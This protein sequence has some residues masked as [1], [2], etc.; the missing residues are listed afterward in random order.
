MKRSALNRLLQGFQFT[1]EEVRQPATA[2]DGPAR[3]LVVCEFRALTARPFCGLLARARNRI[4]H[5]VRL[6]KPSRA[7]RL[8][9]IHRAVSDALN[10]EGR[11]AV[12][13][14]TMRR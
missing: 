5:I 2:G 8:G 12:G 10:A 1:T 9:L 3:K 13:R 4:G 11:I 7:T 6:R 14:G